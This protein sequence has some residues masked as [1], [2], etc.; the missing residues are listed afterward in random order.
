MLEPLI[1]ASNDLC[2]LANKEDPKVEV[3]LLNSAED[4]SHGTL[5]DHMVHS[6]R[7]WKTVADSN[8]NAVIHLK[9]GIRVDEGI[10]C[11]VASQD[12]EAG[13]TVLSL[14]ENLLISVHL[15]RRSRLW[16]HIDD[17]LDPLSS[18]LPAA[19]LKVFSDHFDIDVRILLWTIDQAKG[20]NSSN[21]I[22]PPWMH[23][24]WQSLPQEKLNTG[25]TVPDELLEN[26]GD[27][28]LQAEIQRYRDMVVT[29]FNS[30]ATAFRTIDSD[31]SKKFQSVLT[32]ENYVWAVEIWAAY[33]VKVV[34]ADKDSSVDDLN[35]RR[36]EPMMC[37]VPGL[38]WC[39]HTIWP[40][41]VSFS[42]VGDDTN[43]LT[44]T[45]VRGVPKGG[46]F[47][48][49]YGALSNRELLKYYGFAV[50]NNPY[51]TLQ[52]ELELEPGNYL[53]RA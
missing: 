5:K 7:L 31:F 41:S 6:I 14:P 22:N 36:A 27:P 21:S 8:T 10:G 32:L 51:D 1:S 34:E 28:V 12:I 11:A 26:C 9:Y 49:G 25:L 53:G 2:R 40:N 20:K 45:A 17:M 38:H 44:M 47:S 37:L 39:N 4:T 43:S 42:T 35:R 13:D 46:E 50:P 48:I 52:I 24:F 29:Q 15:A 18:K 16:Q 3:R 23:D 33:A 19:T 30:V